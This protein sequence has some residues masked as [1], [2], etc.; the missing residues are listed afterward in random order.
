M[1]YAIVFTAAPGAALLIL[2]VITTNCADDPPEAYLGITMS[3]AGLALEII[4]LAVHF[5]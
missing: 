1:K 5:L 3:L 4:A 2:G